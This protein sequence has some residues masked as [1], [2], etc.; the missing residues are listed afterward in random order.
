[1]LHLGIN[2]EFDVQEAGS[3]EPQSHLLATMDLTNMERENRARNG[4]TVHDV[5]GGTISFIFEK[6]SRNT[7]DEEADLQE[8]E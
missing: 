2:D 1:M 7:L 5:P 4:L 3:D 8:T 6:C